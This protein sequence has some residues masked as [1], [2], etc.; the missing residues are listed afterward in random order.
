MAGRSIRALTRLCLCAALPIACGDEVVTPAPPPFATVDAQS[1]AAL[2]ADVERAMARFQVPGA[3]VVVVADDELVLARPFGWRNVE[4][5][6]PMTARTLFQVGGAEALTSTL[7][8][9]LVDDDAFEWDSPGLVELFSADA[10]GGHDRMAAAGAMAAAAIGGAGQPDATLHHLMQR[11]VFGPAGMTM[12]AL[13]GQLAAISEDFATPYGQDAAGLLTPLPPIADGPEVASTAPDLARFLI[14][15]LQGGIAQSGK[16][17]SSPNNLAE[18]R[19]PR[20]SLGAGEV[21]RWPLA[22][23]AGRGLGWVSAELPWR[24]CR[25]DGI[26]DGVPGFASQ[27]GFVPETAIGLVLLSN[28]DLAQGGEAFSVEVRDGFLRHLLNGE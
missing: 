17:V 28:K 4:K 5:R 21:A 8:S 1:L 12:T 11:K 6:Q 13:G 16:R 24:G 19:R 25:F 2:E 15:H 22:L 18:T 3:V 7:F 26:L 27:L 9:T 10:A 23:K 20:H 14:L